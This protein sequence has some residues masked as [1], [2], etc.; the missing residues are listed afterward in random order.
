MENIISIKNLDFA[1]TKNKSQFTNL[2]LSIPKGS[3]YGFLGP[4]GAGKSTL[5]RLLLG[6]VKPKGGAI[7][8]L[9]KDLR[10]NKISILSK[11]GS[12]IE[13]P[14][15]YSHLTGYQNLEIANRYKGSIDKNEL[16]K[17][18]TLVGLEH[19]K[20]DNVKSYS[21]GMKQRLG[22]AIAMVAEPEL[23]IL[24]EPINGLDPEGIKKIRSLLLN[25][26]KKYKTTIFISSHLLS[27]I[28]NTCTHIAIINKGAVLYNGTIID[29]KNEKLQN[30]KAKIEV[31]DVKTTTQILISKDLKHKLL[32]DKWL[33]FS[34][35]EK[36]Q[37]S[38]IIKTLVENNIRI[39]QCVIN[40]SLEKRYL[41]LIKTNN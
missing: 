2:N 3:I 15:L 39:T 14:S 9:G 5:I 17:L 25:I 40:N 20:D 32:D 1:Y 12:L 30:S 7:E 13:H 26:N 10:N 22:I 23:L 18:L 24:D 8:I 4:N 37:V 19:A 35:E 6:L 27:E 34:F 31:D 38:K 29:F 36:N 11:I 16:I 21:L 33:E 28:E 41:E